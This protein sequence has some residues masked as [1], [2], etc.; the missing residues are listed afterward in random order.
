M[1]S[2]PMTSSE[3]SQLCFKHCTILLH[4]LSST[5]LDK[6]I[7][8]CV[9]NWLTGQAQRVTAKK[10]ISDWRPVTNGALQGFVLGPVLFSIFI[11]YL[12]AGLE[13]IL[14][15]FA[16]D[17]KQGGAVDSLK[18]RKA[19]QRDTDKI[20]DWAIT[21]HRNFNNGKCQILHLGWGN[22]GCLYRLGNAG[23]KCSE[24]DLGVL[25]DGKLNKSQ[26][27]P[28]SQEG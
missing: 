7:M 6:H 23:K 19:L 5:Q 8:G 17:T 26:Q 9:R 16:D 4:K 18:G 11:N 27:C 22:P 3:M 20:E 24:R 13:G 2:L 15:K 1:A 21:N 28:G 25:V 10:V 12:G 14:S